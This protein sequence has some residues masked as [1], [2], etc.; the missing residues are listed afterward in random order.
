MESQESSIPIVVE[1]KKTTLVVAVI[2]ILVIIIGIFVIIFALRPVDP[3]IMG[4]PPN[5]PVGVP[6]YNRCSSSSECLQGVCVGGICVPS[7]NV[8]L[9]L[10]SGTSSQ[11]RVN[12]CNPS[13]SLLSNIVITK[14]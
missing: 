3:T 12:T 5:H 6:L 1:G 13:S 14:G 10:P 2:A 7:S 4:P 11:F 8:N 9:P